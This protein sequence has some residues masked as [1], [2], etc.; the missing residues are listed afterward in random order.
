[1]PCEE[2]LEGLV[3]EIDQVGVVGDPRG[4]EIAETD[5]DGRGEQR[6]SVTNGFT[7]RQDSALSGQLSAVSSVSRE[8]TPR[9]ER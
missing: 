7:S 8:G 5:E 9:A 6:S 1:V 4:V 3:Q 2:V